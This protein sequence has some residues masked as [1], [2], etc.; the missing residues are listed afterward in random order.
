MKSLFITALLFVL[1]RATPDC[2]DFSVTTLQ[3]NTFELLPKM[4]FYTHVDWMTLD[5]GKNCG[6][7]TYGDVFIKSYDTSVSGIYFV[8]KKTLGTTCTL[9][10][11]MHSF[12]N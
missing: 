4:L 11:T 12:K 6:F 2:Y 7:Y 3:D 9:D 10:S 5:A 1:S 8:F